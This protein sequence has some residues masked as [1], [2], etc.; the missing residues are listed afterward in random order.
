MR[1]PAVHGDG[2]GGMTNVRIARRLQLAGP[3]VYGEWFVRPDEWPISQKAAR[4]RAELAAAQAEEPEAGWRL[5]TRG[6]ITG[7]HPVEEA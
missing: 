7:W 4:I 2:V 6:E 5:E 1:E 3:E